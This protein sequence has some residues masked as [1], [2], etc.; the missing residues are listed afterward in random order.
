MA[1]E[2]EGDNEKRRALARAARRQGDRPS[3]DGVTL[4]ASKQRKHADRDDRTG[5]PPAGRHKPGPD[6]TRP[7]TEPAAAPERPVHDPPLG[8]QAP[9]PGVL[10]LRYRELVG[11]TAARTGRSFEE[12]KELARA[13]VTVLARSLDDD[14]RERLIEAVPAELLEGQ[15]LSPDRTV[16]EA[17]PFVRAVADLAG[18]PP[19]AARLGA[20]AVLATI[21]EQ[22][23]PMWTTPPGLAE[24]TDPP[25]VGGGVV[26]PAGHTAPLDPDEVAEALRRLPDWS[27]DTEAL[28]RTL[29]LPPDQLDRV[30]PRLDRLKQEI[31]RAPRISRPDPS[32]AQ[33]VVRTTNAGAVTALDVDLARRIDEVIADAG[34][35]L[36]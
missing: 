8:D 14:D 6:A 28:V 22:A 33:L 30:L 2:M 27:G 11:G 12:A 21:R 1:K 13:T 7:R 18:R 35:G 36:A 32:T 34:G 10:R 29:E 26:G 16:R 3:A 31:G 17:T 5:P 15:D 25:D 19:E 20:Q 24:L 4:G 23:P 9:D